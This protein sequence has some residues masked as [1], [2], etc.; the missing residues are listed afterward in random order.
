MLKSGVAEETE[1]KASAE[2]GGGGGAKPS[3]PKPS[4]RRFLKAGVVG[5]A[6]LSTC[7]V[8]AFVRTRGYDL[9]PDREG[10]L[11]YLSPWQFI[12]FEHIARRIA[13]PDVEGD[14]AVPSIEDTDVVGFID[15]YVAEMHPTVR[16]D[17]M[18]CLAYVEH[19]A[20]LGSGYISRFT[21]LE[22]DEQDKVLAGMESSGKDLLRGGFAG[23]KALVFMGYYRDARTWKVLAYDGPLVGRPQGGWLR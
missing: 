23:L 1:A 19:I 18:R 22:P 17:L 16:R 7:S 3:K 6:L 14:M 4:R 5:G 12:V 10:K 9:P 15:A 8:V 21:R 20:P 2:S 13:A 11:V